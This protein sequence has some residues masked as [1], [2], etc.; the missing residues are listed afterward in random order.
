M[1]P[2]EKLER[3]RRIVTELGLSL[4]G[5][6]RL[7]VSP[8]TAAQLLSVSHSQVEKLV[9]RGELAAFRVGRSVRIELAELVAFMDRNRK[10][11]RGVRQ[12]SIRARAIDLIE[13]SG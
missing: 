6:D 9:A 5:L 7:A 12:R 2:A 11:R 8:R 4:D 1:P 13:R 3:A 10:G